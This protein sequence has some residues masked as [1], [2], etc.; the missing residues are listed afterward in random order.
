MTLLLLKLST[1][2]NQKKK[3]ARSFIVSFYR[4]VFI[5]HQGPNYMEV[6]DLRLVITRLGGH[7]P[8]KERW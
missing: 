5:N 6:G 7:E 8:S 3:G 4:R 1:G 2:E